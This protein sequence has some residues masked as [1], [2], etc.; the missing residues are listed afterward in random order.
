MSKK[1]SYLYKG[2]KGHIAEVARTLPANPERLIQNGWEDIS[3][4]KQKGVGSFVYREKDTGLKIR[5]DQAKEGS[6]GFRG[7]DHYHIYNPNATGNKDLYLDKDGNPVRK[8]S[9]KSHILSNG[10]N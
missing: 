1:M 6:P 7:M 10:G 4:P 3:H 5:F 8:S 2:T 9:T